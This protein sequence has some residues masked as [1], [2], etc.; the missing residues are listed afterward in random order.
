M[1]SKRTKACEISKEVKKKYIKEMVEDVYFV[2]IWEFQMH[3]LFLEV[4]E[5]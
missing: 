5:V 2:V 3:I 4:Q 1:K